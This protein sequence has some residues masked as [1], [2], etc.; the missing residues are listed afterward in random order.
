MR[1]WQ[2]PRTPLTYEEIRERDDKVVRYINW[3]WEK[4]GFPP[5][6]ASI[7][8]AIEVSS[9]STVHAIISRLERQRRIARDP[10][11]RQIKIVN[12]GD[13]RTC[14]HDW[15]VR[16]IENGFI[17]IVCADCEFVTEVEYAP[18]PETPL[19]DLLKY[20]GGV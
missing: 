7:G 17:Q 3:Y 14:I 2:P 9:K 4:Y 10:L 18:T 1:Q 13:R 19:K 5:S 16:K 15:R 12:N 20:M 11:T 8:K 6:Y